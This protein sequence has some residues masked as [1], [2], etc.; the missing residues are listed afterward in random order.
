ME[1]ADYSTLLYAIENY[2]RVINSMF[3]Q[4]KPHDDRFPE[5]E[6]ADALYSSFYIL[7]NL[8]IMLYPFAPKTITRL[9]ESLNLDESVLSIDELGK[10]IEAG[11]KIGELKEYFP[12]AE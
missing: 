1:R 5:Q 6:R 3:S 8:M 10:P 12:A 7:K 11:H 4:Y 2:A 9:R